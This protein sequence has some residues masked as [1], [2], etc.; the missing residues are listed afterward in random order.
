MVP[1]AQADSVVDA[2]RAREAREAETRGRLA[3]GELGL[4]LYD[5]R[6]RLEAAGLVYV[7]SL[8]DIDES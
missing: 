5:M 8:E 2:G 4:D 7:D 6:S 3:A 1:R